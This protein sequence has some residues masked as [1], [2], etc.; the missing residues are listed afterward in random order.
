MKAIKNL[1]F[2][3]GS[4]LV[5]YLLINP[6]SNFYKSLFPEQYRDGAFFG[7]DLTT[8]LIAFVIGFVLLSVSTLNAFGNYEKNKWIVFALIIS[9]IPILK[10]DLSHWYFYVMLALIGWGLGWVI[11][12]LVQKNA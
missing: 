9:F 6:I 5:S 4:A 8:P 2:I 11:N 10:F 12:W 3:F 1:L 7:F